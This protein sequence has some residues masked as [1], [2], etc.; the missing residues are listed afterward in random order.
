M[1]KIFVLALVAV[2][3]AACQ[4]SGKNNS[5]ASS[6]NELTVNAGH[7]AIPDGEAA[8]MS[9]EKENYNFGKISQGEKISYSYKVKNVG[10]SPLIILNATATCGCTVPEI[11]AAPI[12][13][14]E[15]GEIKVV[16]DSQGK[17][18]IQDKVI[19]VTSNATPNIA[20]LHLTGEID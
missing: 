14:G 13:P 16:F 17:S 18:G 5:T 1:K 20:S 3:F 11:P 2:S 12:K 10:K 15:E 7:E 9:F 8:V 6:A 19:T 4:N